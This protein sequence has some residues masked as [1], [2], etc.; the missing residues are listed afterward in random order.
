MAAKTIAISP[1]IESL[2][3]KI[4]QEF[5]P[6]QVILFG[7]RA[8]GEAMNYSDWDLLVISQKFESVS[9]RGRMDKIQELI[10]KPIG[11]DVK[12]FCYTPAETE[13][14]KKEIGII[15]TVIETGITI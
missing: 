1:E 6:A 10:E 3:K 12:A 15:K 14:R 8:R 7:S 13:K 9:F 5:A 2:E 4:K 11:Q